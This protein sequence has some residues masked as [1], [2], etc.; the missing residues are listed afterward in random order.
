M[1]RPWPATQAGARSRNGAA[2]SLRSSRRISLYG[3][4]GII[5]TDV[6]VFATGTAPPAPYS[7]ELLDIDM[8]QLA[9]PLAQIAH[10]RRLGFERRQ[11]TEHQAAQNFAYRRNGHAELPGDCR[12]SQALPPSTRDLGDPLGR[13][14]VFAVLGCRASVS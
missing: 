2:L 5:D 1:M 12:A 9:W 8:D 13:G 3:K 4:R 11:A 7:V 10:H 6:D 14:A